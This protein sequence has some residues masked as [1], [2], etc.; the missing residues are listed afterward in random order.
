VT[1]AV[2]VAQAA[3]P[4]VT[5]AVPWVTAAVPVAQAAVRWAPAAVPWAQAAVPWAQATVLEHHWR[6]LFQEEP[7]HH[8]ASTRKIYCFAYIFS[9]LFRLVSYFLLLFFSMEGNVGGEGA[10]KSAQ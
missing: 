2:P 5:A 10:F 8:K 3:V 4:W 7:K 1:A 6:Q 9:R